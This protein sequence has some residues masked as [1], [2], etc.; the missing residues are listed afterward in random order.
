[1]KQAITRARQQVETREQSAASVAA[2][3][4]VTA[5]AVRPVVPPPASP[6]VLPPTARGPESTR[7]ATNAA[8]ALNDENQYLSYRQMLMGKANGTLSAE[9]RAK[10]KDF[11]EK[12]SKSHPEKAKEIRPLLENLPNFF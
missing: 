7:V 12:Y 10:A 8:S 6:T 9:K 1:V 5:S 11:L 3:V 4:A 2:R